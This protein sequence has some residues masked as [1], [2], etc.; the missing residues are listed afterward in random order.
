MI[1]VFGSLN[2]DYV[3]Q[4]PNIPAPGQTLLAA[5]LTV[6]PGGKGA[7][8]ALA[9]AKAGAQVRMV[10]AVGKDG[11]G[12]IAVAGLEA[13]GVDISG[14]KQTQLPTGTAAISVDTQGE[15]AIIVAPG[16]NSEVSH[17]QLDGLLS[18]DTT[19]LL[20]GEIPMAEMTLAIQHAKTAGAKVIWNLAPMPNATIEVLTAVDVVLVNESE[21]IALGQ[22]L[23]IT[24]TNPTKATQENPV[25]LLGTA[26][27]K[28]LHGDLVVTLGAAGCLAW[29]QGQ[30]Y[31]IPTLSIEPV[32]TVG[33]GDAFAG[34]FATSMDVGHSFQQALQWGCVAGALACQASGAQSSLPNQQQI[35][36]QLQNLQPKR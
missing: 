22:L 16:A 5:N 25:Q 9:A 17:K 6:L 4:V 14:I 21:L 15:N 20:Q 10:G 31:P 1:V 36:A 11:L 34:A 29:H 27:A 24:P 2:V 12:H 28:E 30:V 13:A 23:G 19:L 8:Q 35:L 7:N 33:A 3:F 26:V 32:D 18:K